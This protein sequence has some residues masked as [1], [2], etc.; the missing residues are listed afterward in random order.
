MFDYDI[1]QSQIS[2]EYVFHSCKCE[3][4]CISEHENVCFYIPYLFLFLQLGNEMVDYK[5]KKKSENIS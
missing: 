2:F 1:L 5:K 3:Q 4:S